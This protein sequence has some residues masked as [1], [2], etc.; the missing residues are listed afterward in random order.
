MDLTRLRHFL[1]TLPGTTEDTPFGPEILVWP[2]ATK[3]PRIVVHFPTKAGA[4][5][6]SPLRKN[7]STDF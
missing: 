5:Y 3:A 7:W 4:L 1:L 6:F 2:D